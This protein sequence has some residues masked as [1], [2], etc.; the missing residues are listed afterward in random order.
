VVR[1]LD[2]TKVADRVA[3]RF[4]IQIILTICSIFFESG[5]LAGVIS[6]CASGVIE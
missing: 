1:E 5:S 2:V 6:S 4:D 3:D